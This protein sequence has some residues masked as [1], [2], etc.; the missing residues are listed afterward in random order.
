MKELIRVLLQLPRA[1]QEARVLFTKNTRVPSAQRGTGQERHMREVID[2]SQPRAIRV[3]RRAEATLA[4]RNGMRIGDGHI[5]SAALQQLRR[6][7]KASASSGEYPDYV[8]MRLK[9][10]IDQLARDAKFNQAGQDEAAFAALV[11][12]AFTSEDQEQLRAWADNLKKRNHGTPP[13]STTP[14]EGGW[15]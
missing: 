8:S 6:E 7:M 5:S 3:F 10:K 2:F 14:S 1:L 12:K 9:R 13:P 11:S 4:R 15:H